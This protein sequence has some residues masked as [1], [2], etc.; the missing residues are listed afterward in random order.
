[1][2]KLPYRFRCAEGMHAGWTFVYYEHG[3]VVSYRTE[4]P[5][6]Y[7]LT[8]PHSEG[9]VVLSSAREMTPYW[10]DVF[11]SVPLVDEEEYDRSVA[12]ITKFL[13]VTDSRPGSTATTDG[14][15]PTPDG[16]EPVQNN[17]SALARFCLRS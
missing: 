16:S 11:E 3:S 7:H 1:M 5:R 17:S 4:N 6:V 9:T 10:L 12:G 13:E 14:S 2:T 15:A 8:P